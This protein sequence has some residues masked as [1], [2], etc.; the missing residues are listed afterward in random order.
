MIILHKVRFNQCAVRL[1]RTLENSEKLQFWTFMSFFSFPMFYS[2]WSGKNHFSLVTGR[3]DFELLWVFQVFKCS[4]LTEA[5]KIILVKFSHWEVRFTSDSSLLHI[6]LVYSAGARIW[7]ASR[8][9]C[10][11]SAPSPATRPTTIWISF[12]TMTTMVSTA[13]SFTLINL[14]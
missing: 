11:L 13:S 12:L 1:N 3:S 10:R 5:K 7:Q 6:L 8:L 4:I 14:S 9:P 2:N